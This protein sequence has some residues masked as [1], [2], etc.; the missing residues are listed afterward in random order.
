[1]INIVSLALIWTIF[2]VQNASSWTFL[3]T[4]VNEF[5]AKAFF[6]QPSPSVQEIFSTQETDADKTLVINSLTITAY[7]SE[8]EQT[9]N[10]PFITASGKSVRSGIVAANFLPFGTKIK[11]PEIF[12]DKVFTVEDRMAKKHPDKIDI[13]FS[14]EMEALRFGVRTAD[15]VIL[16]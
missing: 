16:D 6:L 5:A 4:N 12:G 13:W 2:S 11:I 9:D 14:S 7:S 15:V 1:M 3:G 8:P 10:D